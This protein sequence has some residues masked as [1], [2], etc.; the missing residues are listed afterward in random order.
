MKVLIF[1]SP[2]TDNIDFKKFLKVWRP[3]MLIF[4]GPGSGSV[5]GGTVAVWRLQVPQEVG[6]T[7]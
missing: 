2:G 1:R 3:N 4:G 6:S 5:G 7:V